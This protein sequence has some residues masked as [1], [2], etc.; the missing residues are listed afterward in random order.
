ME[1]VHPLTIGL[2]TFAPDTRINVDYNQRMNEWSL[3]IQDIRPMDEGVY[4]CQISTKNDHESY[5]IMLHV[6]C[7]YQ[8]LG[9]AYSKLITVAW[10]SVG[11]V[12]MAPDL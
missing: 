9:G 7:M 3:I 11:L 10:C 12:V 6:R 8:P 5:N 4:Q 2:Y 1:Q